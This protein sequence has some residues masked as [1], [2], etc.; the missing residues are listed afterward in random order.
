MTFN[1]VFVSYLFQNIF[2]YGTFFS[3]FLII[4]LYFSGKLNQIIKFT[5]NFQ[6]KDEQRKFLL[7]S[8]CFSLIIGSYSILKTIKEAVFLT[9][10]AL[11]FCQKLEY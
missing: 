4:G 1:I 3:L 7:L 11:T 2:K 6:T 8:C 9:W 5:Y 10:L